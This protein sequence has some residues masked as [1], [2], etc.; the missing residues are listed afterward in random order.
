MEGHRREKN[1]A[2]FATTG[3]LPGG[4]EGLRGTRMRAGRPRSQVGSTS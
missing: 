2:L 1:L 4:D 3:Y